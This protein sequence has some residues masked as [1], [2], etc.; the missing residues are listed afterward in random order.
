MVKSELDY[1]QRNQ[2]SKAKKSKLYSGENWEPKSG[3]AQGNNEL[4]LRVIGEPSCESQEWTELE[5]RLE[6]GRP[7]K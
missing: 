3:F 1:E 6:V 7:W 5:L 2:V 4:S